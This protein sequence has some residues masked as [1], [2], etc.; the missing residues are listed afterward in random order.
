MGPKKISSRPSPPSLLFSRLQNFEGQLRLLRQAQRTCWNP[1]K[2]PFNVSTSSN[3]PHL[4]S[5]QEDVHYFAQNTVHLTFRYRLQ[6]HP[7]PRDYNMAENIT[8]DKTAAEAQHVSSSG[9][10]AL[11]ESHAPQQMTAK[12]YATTRFSTLKP[13]MHKAPN[14]FK[15]LAM[16]NTKQWMFFLVGFLAWVRP[17]PHRTLKA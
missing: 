3:T 13:P 5:L 7:T 12:E 10:P 2:E 17:I 9:D 8:T 14:P 15:L 4:Q 1:G 16:L 11:H 6:R